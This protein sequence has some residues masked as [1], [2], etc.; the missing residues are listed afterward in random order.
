MRFLNFELAAF[1]AATAAAADTQYPVFSGTGWAGP[2]I[3]RPN[4]TDAANFTSTSA[5][6]IVPDLKVPQHPHEV[7]DQYS[8]AFW[9]GLDGF[10]TGYTPLQS[11]L[12]QVGILGNVSTDGTTEWMGFYEWYISSLFATFIAPRQLQ[13]SSSIHAGGLHS[14]T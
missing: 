1:L 4:A 5:T 13:G 2:A 12:W 8:A 6:L 7:V 3:A 9:L 11:G 14:C 10:P